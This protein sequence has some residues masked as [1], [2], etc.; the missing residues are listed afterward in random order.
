MARDGKTH[1]HSSR[2]YLNHFNFQLYFRHYVK[3]TQLKKIGKIFFLVAFVLLLFNLCVLQSRRTEIDLNGCYHVYL[4]LGT[5]IGIQVRLISP[6]FS[7]F[8]SF[9]LLSQLSIVSVIYE[10]YLH[11]QS[12]FQVIFSHVCFGF[13]F[14]SQSSVPVSFPCSLNII[15]E[16]FQ[17]RKLYEPELY[18][19]ASIHRFYDAAFHR[20]NHSLPYVCSVGFEPNPNHESD[21]IGDY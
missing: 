4:D 2:R 11:S 13:Q 19:N 20:R 18:K 21:L 16:S 8:L 15:S 12:F 7:N 3:M 10:F 5:N 6:Y 14:S 1:N 9:I 17:I